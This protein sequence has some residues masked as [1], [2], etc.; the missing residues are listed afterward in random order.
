M[1]CSRVELAPFEPSHEPRGDDAPLRL[2]GAHPELRR[3]EVEQA[4]IAAS[5]LEPSL[6]DFS[7]IR[8]QVGQGSTS[9]SDRE[10]DAGEEGVVGE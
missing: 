2:A 5:E 6:F 10:L 9:I 3:A 1:T 8:Q 4:R 7:E